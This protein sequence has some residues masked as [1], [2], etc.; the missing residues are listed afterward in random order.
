MTLDYHS[1]T[2]IPTSRLHVQ[3]LA[4]KS[5]CISEVLLGNDLLYALGFRFVSSRDKITDL[6]DEW[7]ICWLTGVVIFLKTAWLRSVTPVQI[8]SREAIFWW[9]GPYPEHEFDYWSPSRS[10]EQQRDVTSAMS[11]RRCGDRG[12]NKV[13]EPIV[14]AKQGKSAYARL[15]WKC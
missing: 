1:V 5:T 8:S 3:T 14:E 10:G 13:S 9:R 11:H 7:T 15:V 4:S 6:L 12:A 2:T